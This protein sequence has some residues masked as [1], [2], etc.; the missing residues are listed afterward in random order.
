[1]KSAQRR[2]GVSVFMGLFVLVVLAC[3]GLVG[4]KLFPV[5]MESFKM[6]HALKGLVEDPGVASQTKKEIA[7][8]IVRRLDIDGVSFIKES[9]WKE[10]IKVHKQKGKVSI[11]VTWKRDIPLFANLSLVADFTKAVNNQP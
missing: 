9:T 10:F 3:V 8:S 4:L 6:D 1:M 2:R 11:V 5:Y 7:Y